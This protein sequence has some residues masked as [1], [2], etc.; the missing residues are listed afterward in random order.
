MKLFRAESNSATVFS[1]HSE[2]VCPN[3]ALDLLIEYC[4]IRQFTALALLEHAILTMVRSANPCICPSRI[5]LLKYEAVAGF[6]GGCLKASVGSG[7]SQ[8][9]S[10]HSRRRSTSKLHQESA[11]ALE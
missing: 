10:S 4:D 11:K 7:L 9:S 6:P 1:S 2:P 5:V 8:Y 3:D